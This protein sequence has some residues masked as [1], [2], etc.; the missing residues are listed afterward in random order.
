MFQDRCFIRFHVGIAALAI[1]AGCNSNNSSNVDHATVELSAIMQ[2]GVSLPKT[3]AAAGLEQFKV[4]VNNVTLVEDYRFE[5]GTG[6]GQN[7]GRMVY[8]FEGAHSE[9]T[10][11][12]A[13]D[14][15]GAD[16]ARTSTTPAIDFM[17]QASLGTLTGMA[18][19][20]EEQVGDYRFVTLSCMRACKVRGSAASVTGEVIY[21]KD[22]EIDAAQNYVTRTTSD[23]SV[24]PAEDAIAYRNNGGVL[25]R[26]LKPL[27]VTEQDIADSVRFLVKLVFDPDGY[28]FG[29]K[30]S[31][32]GPVGGIYDSTGRQLFVPFLDVVPLAL[33]EGQTVVREQYLMDLAG[34]FYHADLRLNVYTIQEDAGNIY[35]VSARA[36]VDE[37]N[38]APRE[39]PHVML[40]AVVGGEVQFQNFD[41]SPII[42]KFSRLDNVGQTGA[43][44][45]YLEGGRVNRDV[46][47]T[48]TDRRTLQ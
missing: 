21:S 15:F 41:G 32:S 29:C 25:F 30:R 26:L 48:L 12:Q 2:N 23:L 1:I 14:N 3:T 4:W 17:D 20:T 34:E 8:L 47:Y 9:R 38:Q 36:I 11:M 6:A 40:S 42:D 44:D 43:A 16:S 31:D 10:S 19:L 27:T 45:L 13:Y 28:I 37:H 24:A 5:P 35:G 18:P 46:T 7:V 33:R 39:F 22:G